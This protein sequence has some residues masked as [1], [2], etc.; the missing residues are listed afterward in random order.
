[1]NIWIFNHYADTP[2]RQTTRSYDLG[3][4]LVA[5]GHHVTIFA[6]GFNHYSRKEERI[7]PGEMGFSSRVAL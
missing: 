1:V 6:A 4:Q 5:K 7:R 2:D 3:K